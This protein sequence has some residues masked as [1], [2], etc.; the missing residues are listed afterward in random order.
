MCRMQ[1]KYN[2]I[3]FWVWRGKRNAK[4]LLAN[5]RRAAGGKTAINAV[6]NM[7]FKDLRGRINNFPNKFFSWNQSCVEARRARTVFFWKRKEAIFLPVFL[8]LRRTAHKF[9]G[10]LWPGLQGYWLSWS[11]SPPQKTAWSCVCQ[12][13]SCNMCETPKQHKNCSA[14]THY[15]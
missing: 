5:L 14:D 1:A 9:P 2:C 13:W 11:G 7:H 6:I 4:N 10:G 3:Y 12:K 8:C 15:N